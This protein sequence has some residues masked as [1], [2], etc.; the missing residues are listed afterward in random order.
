MGTVETR[1][2]SSNC[3]KPDVRE[4]AFATRQ[5]GVAETSPADPAGGC[6][7]GDHPVE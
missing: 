2:L 5:E 3:D 6:R 7:T 1:S 4:V